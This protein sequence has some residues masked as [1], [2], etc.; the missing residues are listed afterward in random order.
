MLSMKDYLKKI[1]VAIFIGYCFW[2]FLLVSKSIAHNYPPVKGYLL[3]N[4][5]I[6]GGDFI[7]FYTGGK[8]A[9][10]D[11]QKLYDFSAQTAKR[12]EIMD[13]KGHLPFIYPPLMAYIFSGFAIFDFT[14]AF[15]LFTVISGIM[16]VTG[17]CL[18]LNYL[19][20]LDKLS[21]SVLL[22]SIFGFMPFYNNCLTGGQLASIGILIYALVFILLKRNMDFLAGLVLSLG[23]YKPPLF[24]LFAIALVLTQGKNFF[25]GCLCGGFILTVL[26][27]LYVGPNQFLDY[28][29]AAS[30]YT[31]GRNL[32]IGFQLPVEDGM[33]VFALITTLMPSMTITFLV[34]TALF[35]IVLFIVVACL[36]KLSRSSEAYN[37]TYAAAV[38]A[39]LGLSLQLLI[40]DL[41]ILLVPFVIIL[42][43]RSI[44]ERYKSALVACLALFYMEWQIKKIILF[45]YTLHL[46]PF[47][48]FLAFFMLCVWIYF[49]DRM[50]FSEL[51][52]TPS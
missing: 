23:Y 49:H 48:F 42:L 46:A 22:L 40:Y 24:L 36:K 12:Q 6:F 28:I 51:P 39:S 29:V 41:S 3:S 47:L 13:F 50:H 17:L 25:L 16:A 18:L 21:I 31:Y 7:A 33:G 9:G 8:I 19:R 2:V 5:S 20:P 34:Y 38:I 43:N 4:G 27:V 1:A 52:V 26:S 15:Y 30:H 10:S 14:T 35:L 45:G 32:Y 44:P 37:L 11:K